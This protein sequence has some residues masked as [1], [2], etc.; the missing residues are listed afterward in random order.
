MASSSVNPAT[1]NT[2]N[3]KKQNRP[4]EADGNTELKDL[5]TSLLA[6][7]KL[8]RASPDLWPDQIPGVSQFIPLETPNNFSKRMYNILNQ[9]SII[10]NIQ[11]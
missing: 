6:L 4:P 2:P 7:E 11:I 10:S 8:D 9:I 3:Q 5:E 1:S